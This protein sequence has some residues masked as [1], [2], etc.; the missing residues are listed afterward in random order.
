MTP[1]T[2]FNHVRGRGEYRACTVT[3][4]SQN[5]DGKGTCS[6]ENEQNIARATEKIPGEAARSERRLKNRGYHH[7]I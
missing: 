5:G 6:V 2:D 4:Q 3:G 1:S 7:E